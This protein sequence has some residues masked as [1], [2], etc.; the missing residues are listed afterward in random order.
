MKV[1]VCQLDE[2]RKSIAHL[3]LEFMAREM[4]GMDTSLDW[5]TQF[6]CVE[7]RGGQDFVFDQVRDHHELYGVGREFYSPSSLLKLL[8]PWFQGI[9]PGI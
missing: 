8:F 2:M 1:M 4:E 6:P 3:Q 5:E 9:E 7:S